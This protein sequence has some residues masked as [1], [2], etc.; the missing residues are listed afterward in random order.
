MLRGGGD[1]SGA[2]RRE[3]WRGMEV[4]G[5]MNGIQNGYIED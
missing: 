3:I 2:K 5:V 1:L 4:R